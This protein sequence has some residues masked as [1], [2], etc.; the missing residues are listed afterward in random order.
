MKKRWKALIIIDTILIVVLCSAICVGSYYA[1]DFCQS[2]K[3]S[4]EITTDDH[5]EDDNVSESTTFAPEQT[6]STDKQPQ[7]VFENDYVKVQFIEWYDMDI[8]DETGVPCIYLRLNFESKY[9]KDIICQLEDVSINGEMI[10][11]TAASIDIS[12]G[13]SSSYPCTLFTA[14]TGVENIKV[15]DVKEV[16]FTVKVYDRKSLETLGTATKCRVYEK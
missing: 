1:Y 3:E 12:S 10:P 9:D 5:S 8:S 6:A 4:F 13:N 14:N 15:E 16:C 2:L 11:T 7:D